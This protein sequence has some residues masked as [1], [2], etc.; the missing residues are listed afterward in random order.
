MTPESWFSDPLPRPVPGPR[1][2]QGI[3][4]RAL[5]GDRS[6]AGRKEAGLQPN[7]DIGAPDHNNERKKEKRDAC[8]AMPRDQDCCPVTKNVEALDSAN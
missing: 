6:Q 4:E 7:Q 8:S 1:Q 2:D 5:E 3:R